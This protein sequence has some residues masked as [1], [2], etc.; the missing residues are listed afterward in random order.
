MPK[1]TEQTRKRI[2]RHLTLASLTARAAGVTITVPSSTVGISLESVYTV[3]AA[4]AGARRALEKGSKNRQILQ[5]ASVIA[6]CAD[7]VLRG[8]VPLSPDSH[9]SST[10]PA[11]PVPS[12]FDASI[13]D[14]F[15]SDDDSDEG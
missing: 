1:I 2:L 6:L 10:M 14:A 3:R 13:A 9:R 5:A 4:L 15:G 8:A 12:T 11:V 7:K